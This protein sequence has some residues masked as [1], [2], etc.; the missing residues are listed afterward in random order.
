MDSLKE[1]ILLE[2]NSTSSGILI[3]LDFG[4]R[5]EEYLTGNN[6]AA[7]EVDS[8][9]VFTLF[10]EVGFLLSERFEETTGL[11]GVF[12][13][14]TLWIYFEQPGSR[15]QKVKR[16]MVKSNLFLCFMSILFAI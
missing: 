6:L 16:A 15:R 4:K 2:A 14:S 9:R 11:Q 8:L 12:A 10:E 7:E 1:A 5:K 3:D 13:V